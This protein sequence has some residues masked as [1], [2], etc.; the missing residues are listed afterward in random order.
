MHTSA[1][2]NFLLI[3]NTLALHTI[4]YCYCVQPKVLHL[5]PSR[6]K[7]SPAISF[8]IPLTPPFSLSLTAFRSRTRPFRVQQQANAGTEQDIDRITGYLGWIGVRTVRRDSR[9]NVV[10]AGWFRFT[11]GPRRKRSLHCI[12]RVCE[13]YYL[14]PLIIMIDRVG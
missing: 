11:R 4:T 14:P 7:L 10:S 2:H 12:M 3:P 5:H 1:T 13:K 8:L 6:T 9:I